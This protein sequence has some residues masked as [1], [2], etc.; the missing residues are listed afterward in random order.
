MRRTAFVLLIAAITATPITSA[1]RPSSERTVGGPPR[2][3]AD[4]RTGA[5]PIR[6]YQGPGGR[7]WSD[8]DL[9]TLRSL[10]FGEDVGYVV[11]SLT[12]LR[13]GGVPGGTRLVIIRSNAYGSKKAAKVENGRRI[14]RALARFLHGG[15][16]VIGSLADNLDNGGY[17]LP[18]SS[19]TPDYRFS[20]PGCG[21]GNLTPAAVG[22]DSIART[23]DDHPVVRGPDGVA[24]TDD[25]WTNRWI[26]LARGC[27]LAHGNLREGI[28]V[29]KRTTFL[30]TARF[31][32]RLRPILG[33]Y[34]VGRGRVI[35][36]TL[37]LEFSG[38]N[39]RGHRPSVILRNLYAYALTG[40]CHA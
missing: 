27:Y 32:D 40:G 5:V 36:S 9:A 39:P 19:G 38:Q 23:A 11:E 21:D 35:A 10:G 20:H 12:A 17:I 15:G 16:V 3:A 28:T 31:A 26:D 1:A 8:R 6:L 7:P 34:C 33:E 18:G 13:H 14:Q 22:P 37:T 25:D 2:L 4:A 24:G 30:M 29:P